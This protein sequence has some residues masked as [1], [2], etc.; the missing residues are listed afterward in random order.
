[1]HWVWIEPMLQWQPLVLLCVSLWSELILHASWHGPCLNAYW[2]PLSCIQ[3]QWWPCRINGYCSKA[4]KIT[5]DVSCRKRYC[6]SRE[7]N[8]SKGLSFSNGIIFEFHPLNVITIK[9]IKKYTFKWYVARFKLGFLIQLGYFYKNCRI[10]HSPS[11][12]F[13]W[14]R[15][16]FFYQ[17]IS[18]R[19]TLR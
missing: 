13:L 18:Y 10:W 15:L 17:Y 7:R 8:G 5:K 4:G 16:L 12:L 9:A 1:M 6:K 2:M 11:N 3:S 14:S 19:L